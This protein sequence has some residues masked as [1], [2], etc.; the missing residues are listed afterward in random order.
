MHDK[1]H[2]VRCSCLLVEVIIKTNSMT[3]L[4]RLQDDFAH[5]VIGY[6]AIGIIVSTCIGSRCCDANAIYGHGW[7]QIDN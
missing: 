7:W 3:V 6:S 2:M 5:N 1:C 4:A